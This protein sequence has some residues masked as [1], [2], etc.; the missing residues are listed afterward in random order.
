MA[1]TPERTELAPGLDISRLVCGLWQVADLE[2][3]GT[4]LD[5]VIAADSLAAYVRDGFDSFDMADHYGSAEVITGELTSRSDTPDTVRAFTKWCPEPGPMTAEIVRAGVQDRLDRLRTPKVDL[6]QFH[7]WSFDDP[8]WLDALRQ[9]QAL[10]A[11]GLIGAIGV[12]NFD[13]IHLEVALAEGIPIVSNQVSFSLVDRRAAGDLTALCAR[14]G[15]RL[16]A[17]GTLSGGFLSSR[18]LGKP[19]PVDI[20]DWSRMKY[21]RFIDQ[22]GGWDAF[23]TLLGA[24]DRIAR[25][26]GVSLSNV[27]SRWVLEQPAVAATIIGA[28]ISE[29]EHRADNLNVFGFALDANDHALLEAAFAGMPMIAGDCGDEYRKPPF[30]TASGDLSHHL[31]A[32][33]PVYPAS[34]NAALPD[35]A[36][37][38]THS[39]WE[40]I[41]GYCRAMRVGNRV[42]VSGTTATHGDDHAVAPQNAAA[43]ATYVLDKI[44]AAVRAHG[45][46]PEHIVRTR[47]YLTDIDD[48]EAVARVHGR[49]FGEVQ[50]ANTLLQVAALA[51]PYK[52]EI[53][54]E[55]VIPD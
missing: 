7:W 49:F 9:L 19:E 20:P 36:W 54:A 38:L 44:V 37:V 52:V 1:M 25:K 51:G 26:H 17:Y 29:S 3:D 27:A 24:A 43:Q 11:E 15:V 12:T 33:A 13:A 5:P 35:R 6:L 40:P 28:R 18:W 41:A 32:I 14:W 8:R 48:C 16:L 30:L 45:G 50:P 21:K 39:K 10:Q 55:A 46:G 47:V 22:A 23:Q 4:L 42:L 2:K 34:P 53:E 31:S